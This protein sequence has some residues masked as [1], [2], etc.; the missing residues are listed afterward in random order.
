MIEEDP[1]EI[2]RKRAEIAKLEDDK[3]GIVS[4]DIPFTGKEYILIENQHRAMSAMGIG[5]MRPTVV[6]DEIR[7]KNKIIE[8][9]YNRM[10]KEAIDAYIHMGFEPNKDPIIDIP[11]IIKE[12][13]PTKEQLKGKGYSLKHYISAKHFDL[14]NPSNIG[15]WAHPKNI[16]M[17]PKN[18]KI[19]S[20]RIQIDVL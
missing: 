20:D 13:K 15:L 2:L 7:K 3:K 14:S 4:S 5:P 11:G 19:K 10:I 16:G 8:W 1:L 18:R 9:K 12:L 17:I 6:S